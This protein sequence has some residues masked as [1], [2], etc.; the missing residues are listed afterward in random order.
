LV[1]WFFG[2]GWFDVWVVGW[3]LSVCPAGAVEAQVLVFV[4]VSVFAFRT[5]AVSETHPG[6]GFPNGEAASIAA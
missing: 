5:E 3:L 2:V 4:A 1:G 6:L